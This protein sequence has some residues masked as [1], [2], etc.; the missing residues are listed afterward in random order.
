MSFFLQTRADCRDLPRSSSILCVLLFGLIAVLPD[1]LHPYGFTLPAVTR[2]YESPT[3]NKFNT[4]RPGDSCS[5][6]N[7][8]RVSQFERQVPSL[9][10]HKLERCIGNRSWKRTGLL[11]KNDDRVDTLPSDNM[12]GV[13]VPTPRD[14]KPP[15]NGEAKSVHVLKST[16]DCK[17]RMANT[18]VKRRHPLL[19]ILMLKWPSEWLRGERRLLI[20]GNKILQE[21]RSDPEG[22]E[23][24]RMTETSEIDLGKRYR[25]SGRAGRGAFASVLAAKDFK[26]GELVAIKRVGDAAPDDFAVRRLLRELYQ[27]R[28]ALTPSF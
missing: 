1:S 5:F 12:T 9:E 11:G 18:I 10:H 6:R 26:T 3:A 20:L 22:V 27:L 2:R 28:K 7:M 13:V 15:P 19:R 16:Q 25:I 24:T 8:A 17:W 21:K 14:W 4:G 23:P